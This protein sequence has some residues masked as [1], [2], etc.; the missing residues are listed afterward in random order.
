MEKENK[1]IS[2]KLAQE[3]QKVAKEKGFELSESEYKWSDNGSMNKGYKPSEC[4]WTLVKTNYSVDTLYPAYDTAEL[5][6]MLRKTH[7]DIDYWYS[8]PDFRLKL[9]K[10]NSSDARDEIEAE[11]RGKMF[12]CLLKNNLMKND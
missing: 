4:D 7:I 8:Y 2:L 3:L 6:E 12:L 1:H 9:A 11:A 5:G 10:N